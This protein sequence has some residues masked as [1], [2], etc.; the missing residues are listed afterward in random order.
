[1]QIKNN[2]A[3]RFIGEAETWG[4]LDKVLDSYRRKAEVLASVQQ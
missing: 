4:D 2:V 3:G 1:M